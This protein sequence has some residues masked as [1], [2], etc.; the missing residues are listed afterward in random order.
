[1]GKKKQAPKV[2]D[3]IMIHKDQLVSK[4]GNTNKQNRHTFA[5]LRENIREH[6]F[7]ETLIVR[8]MDD[9]SFEV[10]SGN[11]RFKA[12]ALEGIDEFPCVVRDDWDEATMELQSVRRNYSRGKLDKEAFTEQVNMLQE[13]HA[14]E[15]DA[16]FE[17]MGFEDED[18]FAE[19]YKED[20]D[21]VA[22]QKATNNMSAV[23]APKVKMIDDLGLVLSSIFEQYGDTVPQ[24]FIVFPAGGKH[25]MYVSATPALKRILEQV[26]EKCLAD[27]LD[28][29]LAIGGLLSIGMATSNFTGDV[30]KEAIQEEGTEEGDSDLEPIVKYNDE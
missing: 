1:M 23:S 5:Q 28:I 18:M 16:I 22:V 17:G 27:D 10:V 4:R 14:L 9:G 7:D 20:E 29:N 15:K 30:D 13:K 12:G 24:S 8:T 6:G 26:A 2:H 3:I 21:T 19:Y 25:H 11:H